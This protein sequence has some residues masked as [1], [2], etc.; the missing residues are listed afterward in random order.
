[1]DLARLDVNASPS[2]PDR[3]D[4]TA[5]YDRGVEGYVKV[6]SA[7]I[8]PPAQDVVAALDLAPAATVLDVGGGSGALIPSIRVAA[9]SGRI[10]ALDASVE[11]LRAARDHTEAFVARGD[12]LALP[13]RSQSVDAVLLAY[14]LFHLSNPGQ[15]MCEAAR[16]LHRGG[17]TGTVTWAMESPMQAYAVW[18]STL[19]DAGAQPLPR[20]RVD[21]GLDSP[22]AIRRLLTENGFQPMQIWTQRLRHQWTPATYF[23]LAIGNG[24]N[25][26]RLDTL[27]EQT[28]AETLQLAS[29]R[30]A[31][32]QPAD[33]A[34]TG[35]VIC[36]TASRR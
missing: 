15:A 3:D 18:D 1:V 13:V 29:Q 16:V 27:E 10:V 2:V 9:P 21:T 11:M 5:A 35:E 26:L 30:L 36:A 24:L 33:L 7:V 17:V 23:R 25:Q 8:L 4:V 19:T 6:W 20:R 31:E 34:W 14:V 32:L 28:R 12:A 22:D